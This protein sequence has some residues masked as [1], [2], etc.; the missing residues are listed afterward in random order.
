MAKCACPGELLSQK[1]S[2]SVFPSYGNC[3][4]SGGVRG[5]QAARPL[6]FIGPAHFIDEHGPKPDK[7]ER[8]SQTLGARRYARHLLRR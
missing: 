2:R 1:E 5:E 8:A 6:F 7:F 4:R 3:I